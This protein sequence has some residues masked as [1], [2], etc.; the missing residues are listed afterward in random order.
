MRIDAA[1]KPATSRSASIRPQEPRSPS[2]EQAHLEDLRAITLLYEVSQE[3]LRPDSE[4]TACLMRILA[5]AIT[6]TGAAKGN[7][8]LLDL[9]SDKLVI[10]VQ[11]GFDRSFLQF[12][13][14]VEQD[15]PSA[16][17]A[18]KKTGQRILVED[19]RSSELFAGQPAREV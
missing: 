12:F 18:A 10:A 13:A 11:R 5:A 4:S 14:T 17:A 2:A 19:I 1:N 9:P 6:I 3:C 8:Q 16:C 7:I 15:Q